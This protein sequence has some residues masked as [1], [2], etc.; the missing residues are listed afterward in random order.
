[1]S[2]TA[3]LALLALAPASFAATPA[4]PKERRIGTVH[5]SLGDIE[6][7]LDTGKPISITTFEG[8]T[9]ADIK[10]LKV[11]DR[12]DL[13]EYFAHY[14]KEDRLAVTEFDILDLA[15]FAVGGDWVTAEED[16]RSHVKEQG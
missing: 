7:D 2:A 15:Y 5:S 11:I 14:P 3:L 10:G 12:F 1:M 6:I 9:K 8:I 4:R 13:D 16:F